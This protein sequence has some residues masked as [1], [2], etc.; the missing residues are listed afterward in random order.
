RL[1]SPPHAPLL[2]YVL[3]FTYTAPSTTPPSSARSSS[4]SLSHL[5]TPFQ[6][7][8]RSYT[9]PLPACRPSLSPLAIRTPSRPFPPPR[10]PLL[11]HLS[12]APRR[13]LP[14][15]LTNPP[16]VKVALSAH[17][18]IVL[19]MRKGPGSARGEAAGVVLRERELGRSRVCEGGARGRMPGRCKGRWRELAPGVAEEMYRP[20][21]TY[22]RGHRLR[23]ACRLSLVHRFLLLHPSDRAHAK[24]SSPR[25]QRSSSRRR[26]CAP[27]VV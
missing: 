24:A 21:A 19:L 5:S 13:S 15:T 17:R 1:L 22:S 14:R 10:S 8:S 3:D 23:R 6:P 27:A 11:A 18:A 20:D 16:L 2:L 12:S 9:N 4:R 7:L 26:V 25:R